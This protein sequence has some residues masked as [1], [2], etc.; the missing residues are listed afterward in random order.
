MYRPNTILASGDLTNANHVHSGV[1]VISVTKNDKDEN[2]IRL[3]R[4]AYPYLKDTVEE[5]DM[6]EWQLKQSL[7]KEVTQGQLP[8]L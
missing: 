8:L 5:W 4:I 7:W 3:R 6:K 1:K 2:I